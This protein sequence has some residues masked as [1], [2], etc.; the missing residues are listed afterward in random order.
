MQQALAKF[1]D[2]DGTHFFNY[3]M[4]L[5]LG[6]Q[7]DADRELAWSKGKEFEYRFLG[8][9]NRWLWEQGKLR[10]TEENM[11]RMLDM[12]NGQG[13]KETSEGDLGVL[14]MVQAD[15]GVCDRALKNA[16]ILGASPDRAALTFAGFVFATCGQ[17]QKAE[18]NAAKLN[19]EYPLDS[20]LQKSELP[21][22]HARLALQRGDAGKAIESLRPAEWA[23]LG[24]V[25]L[26]VPVYLRGL[27]HLHN[28]HGAEAVAEFNKLL[29]HKGGFGPW[30][31]PTLAKLGLGRAYTLTGDLPKARTAYQDFFTMWKDS[32]PD[33]PLLKQAKSE[34]AN[35]Q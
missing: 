7:A 34:Y 29:D 18:T 17:G 3:F 20:F 23:E 22:I 19:K 10:T 5:T 2:S 16:E 13:L 11:R 32:D 6:K 35:L 8:T 30:P 14:A 1:P 9:Q 26:G 12:E 21:Q 33:V 31:Y 15:F 24:F 28:K 25:E 27:A 4:A